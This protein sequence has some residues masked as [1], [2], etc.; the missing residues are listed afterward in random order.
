MSDNKHFRRWYLSAV[1]P[2]GAETRARGLCS[3]FMRQ[4]GQGPDSDARRAIM[5][6]RQPPELESEENQAE[7]RRRGERRAAGQD[8]PSGPDT[9][10]TVA[11]AKREQAAIEEEEAGKPDER[12]PEA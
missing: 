6:E 3:G 11:P 9:D 1:P 12:L 7:L 5:S 8:T 2:F 10:R 4:Q